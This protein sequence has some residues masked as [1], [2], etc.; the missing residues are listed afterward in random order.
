MSP[1]HAARG[2]IEIKLDNAHR[3]AATIF[4]LAA[5]RQLKPF[6]LHRHTLAFTAAGLVVEDKQGNSRLWWELGQVSSAP[7]SVFQAIAEIGR[8]LDYDLP[9]AVA[10]KLE[11]VVL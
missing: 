3:T 6:D 5:R 11:G 4:I 1:I 7:D 2:E 8:V 9:A 10:K